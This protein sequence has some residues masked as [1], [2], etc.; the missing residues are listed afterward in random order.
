MTFMSIKKQV[1]FALCTLLIAASAATARGRRDALPETISTP[2]ASAQV[3]PDPTPVDRARE[4][5]ERLQQENLIRDRVQSEVDRAFGRATILFNAWLLVL[6]LFPIAM[7]IGLWLL[8]RRIVYQLASE[9]KNLLEQFRDSLEKQLATEIS[10]VLKG[11]M[12]VFKQET[13]AI[14]TE[15][16]TQITSLIS[17]AQTVLEELRQ[18]REIVEQE[19]NTLR[20]EQYYQTQNL[21][22]QGIEPLNDRFSE[23]LE[24]ASDDPYEF[25]AQYEESE[26]ESPSQALDADSYLHQGNA[27]FSEG[28]Y[29]DANSAYSEAIKIDRDFPTA[30][31]Q[32]ARCYGIRGKVNLAIG[33]LQWAIDLDPQY[34]EIAKTDSAFD[35][36]REDEQFKKMFDP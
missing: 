7:A 32:N 5:L 3:T 29:V 15:T 24:I 4:E 11:Q 1:A 30:R 10:T 18:Q 36:I 26:S 13:A 12:E 31:Y 8:H 22:E 17:E 9:R 23:L 21:A 2:A 34:K 25:A 33:N 27:L 16:M 20:D 6:A 19:I 14:R 28:R 35:A